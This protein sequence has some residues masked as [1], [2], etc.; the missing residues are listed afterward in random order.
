M[1]NVVKK[2][3]VAVFT[4][5][6]CLYGCVHRD[7]APV[8]REAVSNISFIVGNHSN[9]DMPAYM[10]HAVKDAIL[11]VCQ[12]FG[13]CSVIIDDGKP[14]TAADYEF[15]APKSALSNEKMNSIFNKESAIISNAIVSSPAKTGEVDTLSS[16]RLAGV[17]LSGTAGNHVIYILDS[18]LS[19][20]GYVDFTQNILRSDPDTIVRYLRDCSALPDLGKNTTVVWI[21]CGNVSAP[22]EDLTP[23]NLKTLKSIWSAIITA[24]GA[25]AEFIDV[26]T[27]GK[28]V[29]GMPEVTPVG[30]V[31]DK[32]IDIS[33]AF[34]KTDEETESSVPTEKVRVKEEPLIL[35]EET[36]L[37]RPDTAEFADYESAKQALS[38]I[39]DFMKENPGINIILAATTATVGSNESC[40]RFSLKRAEAVKKIFLILGISGDRISA[41][42]LGYENSFHVPD[43]N[44]DGTLNENAQ[45]N[46]SV[47]VMDA[48]SEE[49]KV[50]LNDQMA[51]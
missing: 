30:I 38:P 18:G 4:V 27:S 34:R 22:Q 3:L 6:I 31:R 40:K 25:S 35:G 13:K 36:V 7:P 21:G 46:R 5:S 12:T 20:T 50:L 17:S 45:K 43:L 26:A 16:L 24:S 41:V 47:I 49:G 51:S 14:Y 39:A 44:A 37:F 15:S 28:A 32:P 1:K 9:A 42:G 23:A 48:R 33:D 19:T 29:A 8:T 11:T 10:H 2:L